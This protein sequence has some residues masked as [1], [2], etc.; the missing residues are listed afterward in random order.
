M[1][2]ASRPKKIPAGDPKQAIYRFRGADVAS[3]MDAREAIER[4]FPG[5]MLRVTSNFR[6]REHILNHVNLCFRERL[7][8]QAPGYVALE[9]TLGQAEHGLPCVAKVTVQVSPQSKVEFIRE[10]EARTVAEICAQLIGNIRVR[11]SDGRVGP[12]VPGDIALLAPAGTDLWRYER[13]LEDN[14][15]P[16]VS[17]AGRSLFRRQ[18]TQDLV[19]L[20]RALADGRDTLA[21]GAFLV[22]EIVRIFLLRRGQCRA[23]EEHRLAY[24]AAPVVLAINRLERMTA[25]RAANAAR[26]GAPM[27]SCFGCRRDVVG[28][29]QA[30]PPALR[31]R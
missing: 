23:V 13:A 3:Y 29:A 21:L 26:P 6:S 25:L 31:A 9:S 10:E 14:G 5:N 1:I 16:L 8:K 28:A 24:L 17:Q 22:R 18:E 2:G 11:R 15:L 12:L 27:V 30:T 4:Q 19:A 20:V 7:G